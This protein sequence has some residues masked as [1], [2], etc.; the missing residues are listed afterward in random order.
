[1]KSEKV[2]RNECGWALLPV[3]HREKW[4]EKILNT[5]CPGFKAGE[6]TKKAQ[7][8][9]EKKNL[10]VF[11]PLREKD[12][13]RLGVLAGKR[14]FATLRLCAFARKKI[15]ASFPIEHRDKLRGKFLQPKTCSLPLVA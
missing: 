14:F 2:K 6:S 11:A 12:S 7:R 3:V 4:R 9:T 5:T 15:F 8:N 1:V 10:C 13:L